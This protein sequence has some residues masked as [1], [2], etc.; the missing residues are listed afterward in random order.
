M[1]AKTRRRLILAVIPLLALGGVL[2]YVWRERRLD[3]AARAA[4]E[5]GLADFAAGDY[6]RALDNLSKFLRRLEPDALALLR[7]GQAI[8]KIPDPDRTH[9]D[10]AIA[11]LRRSVALEDGS[12]EARGELL[13][14]YTAVGFRTEAIE[15]ADWFLARD[16]RDERALRAKAVTLAEM[17]QF[18]RALAVLATPVPPESPL[19]DLHLLTLALMAK[20]EKPDS[21]ILA[22]AESVAKANGGDPRF[23]LVVARARLLT[24]DVEG[25]KKILG[26]LLPLAKGD[27]RLARLLLNDLDATGSSRQAVD[28]LASLPARDLDSALQTELVRRASESGQP[29]VVLENVAK[30]GA[31]PE[32]LS[33]PVL[34]YH[35][36]ALRRLGRLAEARESLAVLA[37]R[38]AQGVA[39]GWTLLIEGVALPDAPTVAGRIEA[40]VQAVAADGANPQSRFELG[41]AY[42][43]ADEVDLAAREFRTAASLSRGWADPVVLGVRILAEH[44]RLPSAL[45]AA[46]DARVRGSDDPAVAILLS[47]AKSA[48]D[49]TSG[50]TF[51]ERLLDG[52][53]RSAI[54]ARDTLPIRLATTAAAGRPSAAKALIEEALRTD[55]APDGDVLLAC[56][57]LSEAMGLGLEAQC[58]QRYEQV[59]GSTPSLTL[60]LARRAAL[61]EGSAAGLSV[62]RSRRQA[63]G[64]DLAPAW[65]AVEAVYLENRGDADEALRAWKD[66]AA[67][68]GED[69]T[70]LRT[71][72]QSGTSWSDRDFVKGIID[73]LKRA[74]GP[75]C[76]WWNY[77]DVRWLLSAPKPDA[78]AIDGAVQRL[79]GIVD[80]AP[81]HGRARSL[82]ATAYEL[83]GDPRKALEQWTVARGSVGSSLAL[84]LRVARLQ[85]A[86]GDWGA[87]RD[88]LERLR[89]AAASPDAHLGSDAH[90]AMAAMFAQLGDKDSVLALLKA[91]PDDPVLDE[92][93]GRAE[94]YAFAGEFQRA[95]R[96]IG[97]ELKQRADPR[98]LLLA[99]ALADFQGRPT[100]ADSLLERLA[101]SMPDALG[102]ERML[103]GHFL[104]VEDPAR[105]EVHLRRVVETRGAEPSDWTRL[106]ALQVTLGAPDAALDTLRRGREA[107]AFAKAGSPGAVDAEVLRTATSRADLRELGAAYVR[108]VEQRDAA[109]KAL[110]LLEGADRSEPSARDRAQLLMLAQSHAKAVSLQMAAVDVLM[111]RGEFEDALALC[112]TAAAAMPVSPEPFRAMA[113]CHRAMGQPRRAAEAVK[114]WRSRTAGLPVEP[115]LFLAEQSPPT[116]AASLLE[117]HVPRALRRGGVDVLVAYAEAL[118]LDGARPKAE[119]TLA[120]H[121]ASN[122]AA[123]R[124]WVRLAGRMASRGDAAT[125]LSWLEREEIRRLA[126][127][128]PS[129]RVDLA[130][131]WHLVGLAKGR[132]DAREAVRRHLDALPADA[133]LSPKDWERIGQLHEG[134]GDPAKAEAAYRKAISGDP[135]PL[136]AL[137]NLVMILV[138]SGRARE[139]LPMAAMLVAAR[140]D[141][142]EYRDTAAAA[143]L[144][145][146][147]LPGALAH[148]EAARKLEPRNA[149]WALRITQAL[150]DGGDADGAR[151][152]YSAFRRDYPESKMA[153]DVHD[154]WVE[155]GRRLGSGTGSKPR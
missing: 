32:S 110:R 73:R 47:M 7:Y 88:T 21:E 139:A 71:I 53:A 66:V 154:A 13:D 113:Y 83:R 106:L 35:V 142:A 98:S 69:P 85:I 9:L 79:Q 145:T 148:L 143:H 15:Q 81:E 11:S 22:R 105:A 2:A 149:A 37:G 44:G 46:V 144:G 52:L 80:V 41:L 122:E 10:S 16:A 117:R 59:H 45:Q 147:D 131:A 25:A 19:L 26:Q 121:L 51:A 70:L 57:Q 31:P 92:V 138:N 74:T 24:D 77:Y 39:K 3:G 63:A 97:A 56:A 137:N 49:E 72:L 12:A 95:E 125:A 90:A 151:G 38:S 107:G 61:A 141:V 94:L 65:L 104:R 68:A 29:S 115:D 60:A 67:V 23:G 84:E 17:K 150:L 136:V 153:N 28:L 54:S 111:R 155:L 89:P 82:L 152:R 114:E 36:L 62:L 96:M 100:D 108:D 130:S 112:R 42:R 120:P 43:D 129:L 30:W 132:P 134:T 101:S 146:K 48:R 27:P 75:S 123:R 8:R 99:A 124:A 119:A 126:E 86:V 116:E 103:A 135:R 1:R 34:G 4:R 91:L 127:P 93:R 128:S 14:L 140:P 76:T 55:P 33:S 102:R 5:Q 20:L 118:V 78:A 58:V 40:C 87:A 50:G 64:G 18:D 133:V 6:E 109:E